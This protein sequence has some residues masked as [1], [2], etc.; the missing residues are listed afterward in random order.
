MNYEIK[1]QF[2]EDIEK[3]GFAQVEDSSYKVILF[4]TNDQPAIERTTSGNREIIVG[5]RGET[6]ISADHAKIWAISDAELNNLFGS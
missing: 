6:F 4:G 2:A 3:K 5:N 1:D